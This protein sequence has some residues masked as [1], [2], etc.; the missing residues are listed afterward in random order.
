MAN[1]WKAPRQDPRKQDDSSYPGLQ[2]VS[3]ADNAS[4]QF[5]D[6]QKDEVFALQ[7]IY[8]DDFVE[9][10]AAHSAWKKSDPTFD[11][12][13]RSWSNPELTVTLGVVLTATYPR[14]LPLLSLKENS[15]LSES[16]LFRLREFIETRPQVLAAQIQAEPMI[17]ELASGLQ[18]I[19]EDAAQAKA[20][21]LKLPSLEEERAAREAELARV[22]LQQQEAEERRRLEAAREEE[23]TTQDKLHEELRLQRS[24]YKESK[25]K[26][27]SQ[28]DSTHHSEELPVSDIDKLVFDQPC[29]VT[30]PSG[31][32]LYF[33]AV[34]GKSEFRTGQVSTVYS[35]RPVLPGARNWPNLAL[36]GFEIRSAHKDSAQLRKQL[37]FLEHQLEKVKRINHRN[38]LE[39]MDFR[40]DR[41][42][43]ESEA[44]LPNWE[45]YVLMPLAE[46][47]AL[48][49][50]LELAGHLD[51]SKVRSWT[52]DLLNALGHLHSCGIIHQDIHP[53]NILLFR[54]ATGD[55]VPKFADVAYERELL[56]I[57]RRSSAVSSIRS[58]KS[59]Y[60]L[61]PEI[62][63]NSEPQLTQ[64]TDIWDLGVVFLQMIFG[65]DVTQKYQSP[66]ALIDSLSLSSPSR[67][68]IAWF[69][70][71]DPKK[72]PRAFELS[73]SEFLAT[74]APICVEEESSAIFSPGQ[75][76]SSLPHNGP[77]RLRHG[78]S[79]RGIALSRYQE[80]F[81]E[82]AR[83]GKG[84][85]GEVV[86]ARKK[87]DG[88]IYAIKKITQHS[89]ASLTE[90]LK[91]V[92]LLSQLSHPAVVRYYNTWLEEVPDVSDT[93]GE[94]ST[95]DPSTEESRD[96][97]SHENEIQFTTSTGGLDFM[98]SSGYPDVT[99]GYDESESE[100]DEAIEQDGESDDDDSDVG[101]VADG[102]DLSKGQNLVV[103]EPRRVRNHQRPYRTV[104][105]ISMEYCEK[106]VRNTSPP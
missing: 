97:I 62:A 52:A 70:K 11:I 44:A 72:R 36:K 14:S 23:R 68:L 57:C 91:E 56:A 50:L 25:K 21:G 4:T 39:L 37:Q 76:M 24:R 84:G 86:K 64:K 103:P 104:M 30:D 12:C 26:Y 59:A 80:D 90:I 5:N 63:R 89:Q 87:L 65:L 78:S 32:A 69:F 27:N 79:T 74:D 1:P 16:T 73:S 71:S 8:G 95:D 75:S 96:T 3:M 77:I 106:R 85:F 9:H 98:S 28:S 93:E 19:L 105:Y 58:V 102:S 82:E 47:G 43:E 83:L 60:W 66:A 10:K 6:V 81:V 35:V 46:K 54:E 48:G 67:E 61:P 99:F 31:D 42:S 29:K 17:H 51:V 20:Q 92:R 34:V 101:S 55:V 45:V 7:A 40:I 53:D 15:S 88:Q 49:E 33:N 41:S 13:I 2:P 38:V 18:D 22:A 100:D 94:S